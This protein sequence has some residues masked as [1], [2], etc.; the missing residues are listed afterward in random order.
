MRSLLYSST[1]DAI[2]AVIG[3]G[4]RF[5]MDIFAQL[6]PFRFSFSSVQYHLAQLTAKG[7]IWRRMDATAKRFEPAYMLA[8]SDTGDA[9]IP[10]RG[11]AVGALCPCCRM[12]VVSPDRLQ[13]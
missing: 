1:S 13:T 7:V 12:P 2:L 4:W 11:I 9:I 10:R 5:R 8:Q 6:R 3:D